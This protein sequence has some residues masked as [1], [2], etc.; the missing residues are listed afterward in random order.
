L[1]AFDFSDVKNLLKTPK[2]ILL[3]SHHSPDGDALGASLALYNFLIKMGH[4]VNVVVPNAYPDFLNWMPGQEN[5]LIYEKDKKVCDSLFQSCEIL[6]SLDYNAPMR[7]GDASEA[8]KKS[9]AVKILIDHH[10]E[11]EIGAYDFIHS[12]TDISST[13]EFIYELMKYLSR[14]LIDKP[15]SEC[16]YTGIMTDTGSFSFNCN[17]VRTFEIVAEL[18][19]TGMDGARINRLI[20]AN[21]TESRLRLLGYSLSQKLKVIPEYHTAYIF[22]SKEEL[23]KYHFKDGDTEGLVNYALSIEGIRFAAL[24]SERTNKIRVSLRSV[25][26][27]SVNRFAKKHFEGGGHRNAAGGDSFISMN[28]TLEKFEKLLTDYASELSVP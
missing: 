2:S 1:E 6:F 19:K 3:T 18:Y 25:G 20:Y 11:P 24:F 8:F 22:L 26:E 10:V 5:I 16:I 7:I 27:F 14:D 12:K 21:N 15:I 13:S 9:G 23:N 28:K 4:K 17:Y